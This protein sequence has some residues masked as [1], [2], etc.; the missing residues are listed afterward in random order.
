MRDAAAPDR[1]PAM[2]R[3]RPLLALAALATTVAAAAATTPA[4]HA[5]IYE[6]EYEADLELTATYSHRFFLEQADP[7]YQKEVQLEATTTIRAHLENI[8]F[9]DGVLLTNHRWTTASQQ[10]SGSAHVTDRRWDP[11]NHRTIRRDASCAMVS[12]DMPGIATLDGAGHGPAG[13]GFKVRFAEAAPIGAECTGDAPAPD[14]LDL[15]GLSGFHAPVGQAKLDALFTLPGE[16]IGMGEVVQLVR[17]RDDAKMPAYCPDRRASANEE[18]EACAFDWTGKITFR[19][20]SENHFYEVWPE[21]VPRDGGAPQTPAP[22]AA[23]TTPT[24]PPKPTGPVAPTVPPSTPVPPT[25][26]TVARDGRALTV[27][28][29]C[30]RG[31]TGTAVL[32]SGAGGAKKPIAT[33]RFTVKPGARTVTVK[34]PRKALRRARRAKVTL[35][36]QGGA[37]V[38]VTVAVRR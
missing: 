10:S 14:A 1:L 9:R 35:T 23:P 13:Q 15:G 29:S 38:T 28:A 17:A 19:R 34:A 22:P 27:P 7:E 33:V 32:T 12:A 36:P 16:T 5:A 21:D 2:L 25:R 8:V 26:V 31:C 37:P 18:T 3:T 30:P 4:A 24:S 20:V 6:A 11:V